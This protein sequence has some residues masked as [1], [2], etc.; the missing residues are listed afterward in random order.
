MTVR[1]TSTPHHSLGDR[2][3]RRAW[4]LLL[5]ASIF[6]IVFA[7]SANAAEGLT[8]LGPSVVMIGAVA[9]AVFLLSKALKSIDVAVGYAAWTG[10]GTVG[11][12]VL[13]SVVFN[14]AFSPGKA[15]CLVLILGGVVGLHGAHSTD[16]KT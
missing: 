4:A 3:T 13:G 7:L 14:E 8:R 11:T 5:G 10:I 16:P 12:A 9:A 15:A 1:R 2:G 6:E